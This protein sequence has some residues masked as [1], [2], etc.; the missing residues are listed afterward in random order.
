MMAIGVGVQPH[1]DLEEVAVNSARA[2]SAAGHQGVSMMTDP[3]YA[4]AHQHGTGSG[5]VSRTA[6]GTNTPIAASGLIGDHGEETMADTLANMQ[7]EADF[8]TGSDGGFDPYQTHDTLAMTH[9]QKAELSHHDSNHATNG[10][11][12]ATTDLHVN[13]TPSTRQTKPGR[14]LSTFYTP[15]PQPGRLPSSVGLSH[16]EQITILREAFLR[17]PLPNR[18]EM[19]EL[20]DKTGRP[21]GK[22]REYFRQRRSKGRGIEMLEE[23]EEPARAAGWYVSLLTLN[24]FVVLLDPCTFKQTGY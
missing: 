12:N 18:H 2:Q 22:V 11:I 23:L 8:E 6:S 24:C 20:A 7:D 3:T 16:A 9:T 15:T 4:H 5:V 10:S 17:N 19:Q 13:P 1:I 14:A 21:A